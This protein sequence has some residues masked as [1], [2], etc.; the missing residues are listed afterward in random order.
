VIH[1]LRLITGL[2][3]FAY[4]AVH[5]LDLSLAVVSIGTADA[6]LAAIYPVVSS[7][8][9]TALLLDAAMIHLALALWAS[10]AAG[11]PPGA[12]GGGLPPVSRAAASAPHVFRTRR[13]RA[14]YGTDFGLP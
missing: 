5:L 4:V 10:G 13:R 2:V 11:R 1:R 12:A 3:L 6:M 8:P 9:V 7:L 14:L